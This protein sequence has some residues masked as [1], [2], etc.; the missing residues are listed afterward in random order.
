MPQQTYSSKEAGLFKFKPRELELI[1]KH[2]DIDVSVFYPKPP[3]TPAIT[4]PKAELNVIE[5]LAVVQSGHISLRNEHSE[6]LQRLTKLERER[7]EEKKK[8]AR[9]TIKR[10]KK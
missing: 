4:E 2:L 1:A 9:K 5:A 6:I 3:A 8:K 10:K 7:E